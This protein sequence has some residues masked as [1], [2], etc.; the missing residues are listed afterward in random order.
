MTRR[1]IGVRWWYKMKMK[2]MCIFFKERII[3]FLERIIFC[4]P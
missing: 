1:A 3:F 2:M 4:Q